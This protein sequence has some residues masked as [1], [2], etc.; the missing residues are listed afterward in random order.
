MIKERGSNNVLIRPFFAHLHSH[1]RARARSGVCLHQG[2]SRYQAC[3][4]CCPFAARTPSTLYSRDGWSST[5]LD[6]R[7]TL[8]FG[9]IQLVEKA[10][11]NNCRIWI[12]SLTPAFADPQPHQTLHFPSDITCAS[13]TSDLH[14]YY[15]TRMQNDELQLCIF[16]AN[17]PIFQ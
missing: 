13:L 11:A 12:P 3:P 9:R 2:A 16:V 4:A 1:C 14:R 5:E 6:K 7:C 15:R 8:D 10:L 17:S